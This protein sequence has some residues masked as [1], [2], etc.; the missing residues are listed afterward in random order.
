[1]VNISVGTLVLLYPVAN[2]IN[3]HK[4][5][6]SLIKHVKLGANSGLDLVL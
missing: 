5:D 3:V 6:A 2:W 1:M 4:A